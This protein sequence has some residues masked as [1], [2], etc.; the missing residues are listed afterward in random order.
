MKKKF[1]PLFAIISLIAFS[2]T[3]DSVTIDDVDIEGIVAGLTET[4]LTIGEADAT[5]TITV[6]FG[7]ELPS[8]IKFN[9][10][11]SGT[12]LYGTDYT[13]TLDEANGAYFL[14]V[15]A[16]ATKKE[17]S[18]TPIDD[19]SQDTDDLTAI[20]T[21]TSDDERIDLGDGVFTVTIE[22]D[23]I[24]TDIELFLL[25][26]V[27]LTKATLDTDCGGQPVVIINYDNDGFPTEVVY[28]YTLYANVFRTENDG[29][30]GTIQTFT[31]NYDTDSIW[32]TDPSV[33]TRA[34]EADDVVLIAKISDGR[35]SELVSLGRRRRR[36]DGPEIG[37]EGPPP[38][39]SLSYDESG[40]IA[41]YITDYD[42]EYSSGYTF[43]YT[44]NT[45]VDVFN[46]GEG[47]RIEGETP[48]PYYS[49]TIDGKNNP[50]EGFASLVMRL[51]GRSADRVFFHTILPSNLE[52]GY[53]SF[54]GPIENMYS[55]NSNNYPTGSVTTKG[56]AV[57][58]RVSNDSNLRT[59]Q[60]TFQY[61]DMDGGADPVPNNVDFCQD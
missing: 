35:V 19:D 18:F 48:E 44:S 11:I 38:V 22:N 42:G 37:P 47:N 9:V 27:K 45:E 51:D 10:A 16:G 3:D 21:I 24:F 53:E 46:V 8:N 28:D 40:R 36:V 20:F 6:D 30:I 61:A 33:T 2:C 25:N 43:D 12:A 39:T 5:K 49:F 55:Y 52:S 26:S 50:F 56:Y 58:G 4:S 57:D 13:T 14:S 34:G 59:W 32:F 15:P 29:N 23:D 31:V 54:N 1:L 60:L 7:A 17:F 41:S